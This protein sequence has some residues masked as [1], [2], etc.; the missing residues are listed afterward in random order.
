M[1][2]EDI[3]EFEG[4]YISIADNNNFSKG[5]AASFLVNFKILSASLTSLPLIK[6]TTRRIL[7]AD[8][9]Q[10]LNLATASISSV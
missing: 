4:Y 2:F 3:M 5:T 6:S 1:A 8:M 10:F 7:R 9:E